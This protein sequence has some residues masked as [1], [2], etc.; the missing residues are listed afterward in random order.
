[1]LACQVCKHQMPSREALQQHVQI[2]HP[3]V[4][5]QIAHQQQAPG[6]AQQQ[7]QQKILPFR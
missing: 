5:K 2:H 7:Q 3:H 1:M 4:F 6:V